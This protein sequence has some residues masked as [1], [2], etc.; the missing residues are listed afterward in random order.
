MGTPRTRTAGRHLILAAGNSG[1][2]GEQNCWG[3]GR[4]VR[5]K[6]SLK[7]PMCPWLE[8]LDFFPRLCIVSMEHFNRLDNGQPA[9]R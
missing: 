4:C 6:I 7:K 1:Q 8:T 9:L 3:G 2:K 5:F